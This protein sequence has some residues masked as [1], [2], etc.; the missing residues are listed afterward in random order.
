MAS[1]RSETAGLVRLAE[2][3]LRR[4]FQLVENGAPA[5]EILNDTLP[6]LVTEY[7]AQGGAVAAEWYDLE[8]ERAE[9][10]GA[11]YAEPLEGSDRDVSGLIGWALTTATSD[12]AL[13]ALILGG[14]QWR[15]ADHVRFTVTG[16]T[17]RD[18]AARGWRRVGVGGCDFCRDLLAREG[19]SR[20]AL[21]FPAHDNCRCSVE[22]VWR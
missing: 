4:V 17:A 1:L 18:R 9:A 12:A 10:P 21:H 16:A 14:V 5:P 20:D 2:G 11:F 15:I 3:D 19:L 22:P 7:G 6:G 13:A 8:R